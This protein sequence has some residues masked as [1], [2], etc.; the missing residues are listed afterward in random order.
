MSARDPVDLILLEAFPGTIPPDAAVVV[1][2]AI[3]WYGLPLVQACA[4]D[5]ARQ[6]LPSDLALVDL[7]CRCAIEARRN[8]EIML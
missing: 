3:R 4:A 7:A 2:R 8:R 6:A 5:T 1:R